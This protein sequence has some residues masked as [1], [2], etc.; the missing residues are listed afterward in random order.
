MPPG[1]AALFV[2]SVERRLGVVASHF[3]F[4][5][6]LRRDDELALIVPCPEVDVVNPPPIQ[7][8]NLPLPQAEW[9][10]YQP[11]ADFREV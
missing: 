2:V 6:F 1:N 8:A 9:F 7:F 5:L 3:A 11:G 4:N 10:V